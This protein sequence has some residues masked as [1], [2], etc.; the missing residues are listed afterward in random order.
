MRGAGWRCVPSR[1]HGSVHNS[2]AF[3]LAPQPR[4]NRLAAPPHLDTLTPRQ[5]FQ[6]R[7][8]LVMTVNWNWVLLL[9]GGLMI[10]VEVLLG[11]FAGFDLVLIGSTF[12]VGG[13]VGLLLAN[14]LAGFVTASVLC[15]AYI[16]L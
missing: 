15:V 5:R 14:S 8:G 6:G 2:P 11:G 7:G 10:L 9:A 1:R 4:A 16:T 13:V 12:V 3:D